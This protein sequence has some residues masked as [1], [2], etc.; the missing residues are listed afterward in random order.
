MGIILQDPPEEASQMAAHYLRDLLGWE[1]S[2]AIGCGTMS[3]TLVRPHRGYTF[4]LGEVIAGRLLSGTM[5][6]CWRYWIMDGTTPCAILTIM[7]PD[8]KT[9]K[10]RR[11]G[12]LLQGEG[13]KDLFEAL[14]IAEKVQQAGN[15]DYEFRHLSNFE[16]YFEA[17]WLHGPSDDVIIPVPP[18]YGIA[19]ACQP[20]SEQQVYTFLSGSTRFVSLLASKSRAKE[21]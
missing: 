6:R 7:D 14:Q 12:S 2:I 16:L 1:A 9:G 3:S 13:I 8:P 21:Q 18:L 5:S 19:N 10:P 4:T 11:F 20:Y 15:Q 17:V